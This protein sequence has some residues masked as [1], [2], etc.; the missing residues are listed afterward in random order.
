MI[1]KKAVIELLGQEKRLYQFFY[2]ENAPLG[3]VFDIL[4]KMQQYIMQEMK[5]EQLNKENK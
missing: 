2:K 4:A 3:E 1:H 5:L